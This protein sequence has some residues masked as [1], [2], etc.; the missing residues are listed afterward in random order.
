MY[1]GVQTSTVFLFGSFPPLLRR[2]LV[3]RIRD[4]SIRETIFAPLLC[5]CVLQESLG[6]EEKYGNVSE[7]E[8]D[9]VL[10]F[11]FWVRSLSACVLRVL[12]V[13]H[14][15][16]VCHETAKVASYYTMPCC[17]FLGVELRGK[18]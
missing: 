9:E 14:P 4:F 15:R 16:T 13:G 6:L 8:I 11:W 1:G 7:I 17:A 12:V 10:R 5:V 3:D 2:R 18:S